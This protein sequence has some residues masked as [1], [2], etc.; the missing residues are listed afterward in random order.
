MIASLRP[1]VGRPDRT[2]FFYNR[3]AA[4]FI[5]HACIL[6]FSFPRL[7]RDVTTKRKLL[8][9][10]AQGQSE[11]CCRC[12]FLKFSNDQHR[13]FITGKELVIKKQQM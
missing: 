3:K 2:L 10:P 1:H 11:D 4:E 7:I 5:A 9:F 12:C 8:H 6:T 13:G